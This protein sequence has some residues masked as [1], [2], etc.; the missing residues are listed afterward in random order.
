MISNERYLFYFPRRDV[1][2]AVPYEICPRRDV[3]DAVPYEICPRRDVGDADT[4]KM[5]LGRNDAGFE[6]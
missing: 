4:A 3:G 2:D 6:L 1:G 5:P